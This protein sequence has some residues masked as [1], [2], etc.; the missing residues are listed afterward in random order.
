M[1]KTLQ[2]L[3]SFINQ[4]H[5]YP[6][7]VFIIFL[8]ASIFTFGVCALICWFPFLFPSIHNPYEI[9]MMLLES[10]IGLLTIGCITAPIMDLVLHIDIDIDKK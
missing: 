10:G 3:F 5:S 4:V 2:I 8:Y 7:W 1:K 9:G 6:F